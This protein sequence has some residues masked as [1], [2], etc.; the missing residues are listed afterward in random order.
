MKLQTR[1]IGRLGAIGSFLFCL[2]AGLWI[3]TTSGLSK[4]PWSA[5]GLYFIGKAFFVG[6]MLWIVSNGS[7]DTAQDASKSAAR[8][9]GE[10]SLH[11]RN[12]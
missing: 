7:A 10:S 4:E 3:L 12:I 9:S 11:S 8:P 5:F 2:L 1:V 6:P